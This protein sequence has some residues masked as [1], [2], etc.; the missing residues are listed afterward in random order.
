MKTIA[1]K[2]AKNRFG[3]MLDMAQ[4][5]PVSIQKHGRDVAVVLSVEEYQRLEALEDEWW[6]SQADEA[7]KEGFMSKQESEAFLEGLLNAGTSDVQ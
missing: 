4:G 5:E 6:A 1:A 3:Q 2:E 7:L